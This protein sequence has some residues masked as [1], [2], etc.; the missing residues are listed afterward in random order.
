MGPPG[1]GRNPV[2]AR[3]MRHFNLISFT[4]LEE[5]SQ[6]KIF[7]TILKSWTG[8]LDYWHLTNVLLV[9]VGSW[10]ISDDTVNGGIIPGTLPSIVLSCCVSSAAFRLINE[11]QGP[12]AYHTK[13]E[14]KL[15]ESWRICGIYIQQLTTYSK[16]H[17]LYWC[18]LVPKVSTSFFVA[19]YPS[20]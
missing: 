10:E 11:A 13:Y 7:G 17:W 3:L 20:D 12:T 14:P 15:V 2:T 9:L 4:E 19:T 8:E 18:S 16:S 1:G 5:D 6:F